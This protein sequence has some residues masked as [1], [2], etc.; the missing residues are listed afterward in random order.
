METWAMN[1][2]KP[3]VLVVIT[4][5]HRHDA[6]GCAGNRLAITPTLDALAARGVRF[7]QTIA[8]TAICCASRAAASR[9]T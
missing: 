5:D 6:L 1:V 2:Q 3:N 7:T 4:D 8:T 9:G